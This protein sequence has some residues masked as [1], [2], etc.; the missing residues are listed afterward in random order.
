M[1]YSVQK[2]KSTYEHTKKEGRGPNNVEDEEDSNEMCTI[3]WITRVLT[4]RRCKY[5]LWN[6][7]SP[8]TV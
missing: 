4:A 1:Q 5:I 6:S 7:E 2:L 3:K 8:I